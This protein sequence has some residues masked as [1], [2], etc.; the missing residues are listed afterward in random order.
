MLPSSALLT[1]AAPR[2]FPFASRY[3]EMDKTNPTVWKLE[4]ELKKAAESRD[5]LEMIFE[6]DKK[7]LE[8]KLLKVI[9]RLRSP[10]ISSPL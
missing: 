7:A 9:A 1:F 3:H 8:D 5:K 4:R 2:S 10:L 6:R